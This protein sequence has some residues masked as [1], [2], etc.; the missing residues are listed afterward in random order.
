MFKVFIDFLKNIRES[1]DSIKNK[2]LIILSA[3][4]MVF[5]IS[6]WLISLN[7]IIDK[8]NVINEE[9]QIGFWQIFKNGI[10]IA[11][12][13]LIYKTKKTISVVKTKILNIN[14]DIL[15]QRTITIE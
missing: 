15:K 12:N 14:S 7:Y 3:I 9:N 10:S 2:W 6:V 11:E 13:Q 1:D 4:S 5:V 8:K